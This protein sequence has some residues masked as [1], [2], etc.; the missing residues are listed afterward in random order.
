VPD[1]PGKALYKVDDISFLMRD[2]AAH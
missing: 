2:S 1:S